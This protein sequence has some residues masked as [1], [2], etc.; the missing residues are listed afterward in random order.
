[1][2]ELRSKIS[3]KGQATIP[4]VGASRAAALEQLLHSALPSL[5]V[6]KAREAKDPPITQSA[7]SAL[8]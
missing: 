8:R 1:M 7:P 2:K 3:T 5:E 4:G 6:G